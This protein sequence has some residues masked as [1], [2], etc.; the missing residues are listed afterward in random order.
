MK[1]NGKDEFFFL[2]KRKRYKYYKIYNVNRK[3]EN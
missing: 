3:K 1:K 2:I